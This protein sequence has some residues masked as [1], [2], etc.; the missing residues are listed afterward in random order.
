MHTYIWIQLIPFESTYLQLKI[1]LAYKEY[2]LN[3]IMQHK[4]H[5]HYLIQDIAEDQAEQD[6]L[7]PARFE[8]A[9]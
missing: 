1:P 7:Y 6:Y 8:T 5:V 9:P 3:I 2:Q 4:E